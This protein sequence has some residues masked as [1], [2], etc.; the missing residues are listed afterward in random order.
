MLTDQKTLLD[1]AQETKVDETKKQDRRIPS[2]DEF[3]FF[4]WD[5]FLVSTLY[6]VRWYDDMMNWKGFGRNRMS[7]I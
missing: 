4:V 1:K 2:Y 7:S 6:S 3:S 5:A